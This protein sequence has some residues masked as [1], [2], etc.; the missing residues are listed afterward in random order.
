MQKEECVQ[1][2]DIYRRIKDLQSMKDSYI[3]QQN[4]TKLKYVEINSKE[5]ISISEYFWRGIYA[6]AIHSNGNEIMK[7]HKE[8]EELKE[9]LKQPEEQQ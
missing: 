3:Q 6:S 7:L 5:Y 9:K 2:E 8:I 4:T 1:K